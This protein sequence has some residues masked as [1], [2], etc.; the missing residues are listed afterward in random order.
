MRLPARSELADRARGAAEELASRAGEINA[1][2][3]FPVADGDSGTNMAATMA[4]AVAELGDGDPAVELAAGAGRGARGNSGVL[5]SQLLR[6][7][8]GA[9][10]SHQWLT[11]AHRNM[12]AA[13][14][15]P[16]E[17]TGITVIAAAATAEDPV[18]AARAA[19][20][21][22]PD[23]LPALGGNVDAG[24]LGLTIVLEHLLRPAELEVM[25]R[26]AGVEPGVVREE[27]VRLGTSL[28]VAPVG[29]GAQTVHI[30]STRAGEVIERAFGLGAVTGL[31]I[32]ALPAPEP[33]EVRRVVAVV[34]DGSL[35]ELFRSG[36]ARV[37]PPGGPVGPARILLSNGFPVEAGA[38]LVVPTDSLV[39]GVAALAVHNDAAS[40]E[41]DARLMREAA[42]AMRVR[43]LADPQAAQ[44]ACLELLHDGGELVTVLVD[45]PHVA[46][47]DLDLDVDVAVYPADGLGVAVEIGVE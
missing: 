39:Q 46:D 37:V 3:V 43:R 25:F 13:L 36:G 30:H 34:P 45:R 4:A 5:L 35:Q 6:A 11:D 12:V 31:R 40:E 29:E 22:T 23:L 2:N 20:A 17:G 9:S 10:D 33:P 7:L 21:T 27:L 18:A 41:E 19:L 24:A 1:L 14:A 15:E 42:A 32:E 8:I 26:I 44:S 16:V 28:I 38:A 47:L